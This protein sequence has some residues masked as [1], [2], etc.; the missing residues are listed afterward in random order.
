MA[1]PGLIRNNEEA[2][3][4]EESGRGDEKEEQEQDI[5]SMMTDVIEM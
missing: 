2:T 1:P 4:R 5:P 3:E